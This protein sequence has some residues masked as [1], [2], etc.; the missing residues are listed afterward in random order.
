MALQ[1]IEDVCEVPFTGAVR[2]ALQNHSMS[3]NARGGVYCC[4][5]FTLILFKIYRLQ[6]G[7]LQKAVIK[8]ANHTLIKYLI[9]F[10]LLYS[11]IKC[12]CCVLRSMSYTNVLH[13]CPTQRSRRS[14]LID[15]IYKWCYIHGVNFS[16]SAGK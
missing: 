1:H 16:E 12:M 10:F 4:S 14:H 6:A 8:S 11:S 7:Q 5:C 15:K 13:K 2:S 9:F 3:Q